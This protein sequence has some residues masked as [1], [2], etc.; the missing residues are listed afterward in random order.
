MNFVGSGWRTCLI[1]PEL[2]MELETA[3][4]ERELH[5]QMNRM[6]Q[7]Q[8]DLDE[9]ID[10]LRLKVRMGSKNLEL[11]LI[12]AEV[13]VIQMICVSVLAIVLFDYFILWVVSFRS[14]YCNCFNYYYSENNIT[15][16]IIINLIGAAIYLKK[17]TIFIVIIITKVYYYY[18]Y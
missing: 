16:I 13:K 3:R 7:L 11:H 14:Y 10:Q 6:R 18:H 8:Y 12:E 4:R 9:Y 17:N 5:A 2:E 15:K 1:I